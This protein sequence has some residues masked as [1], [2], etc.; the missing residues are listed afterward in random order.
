MKRVEIYN[1]SRNRLSLR[2]YDHNATKAEMVLKERDVYS[3][4]ARLSKFPIKDIRFNKEITDVMVKFDSF[5][6]KLINCDKLDNHERYL[7][8]L[9]NNM[10]VALEKKKMSEIKKSREKKGIKTPPK[11][12]RSNK[13]SK[14]KIL[15]GALSLY[16]LIGGVVLSSKSQAIDTPSYDDAISYNYFE[17]D[18]DD[19]I[20][21]DF[22]IVN[23]D[24]NNLTEEKTDA[25]DTES[26][27]LEYEDRSNTDKALTAKMQYGDIIDKYANQYG[28]DNRLVLAI[29]TQERGIHSPVMDKGG[30]TGLMQIQN[31][32]WVGNE[33]K[34]YNFE[35]GKEESFIIEKDMLSDLNKNIQIGCMVLQNTMQYMNYNILAAV[36]CYNM[37]YGNMTKILDAYA[38]S[39]GMTRNEVLS[40]QN[41]CGWL[42]YR[43]MI[44]VGDQKYVEHV[45]SWMGEDANIS[46]SSTSNSK[47]NLSVTNKNE[48][49]KVY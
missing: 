10:E 29:A 36:Q 8:P 46:V 27:Y 45:L 20:P 42:E 40:D 19:T 28:L 22:N 18:N 25:F 31:S 13:H 15:A 44:K 48:T 24:Y 12:A 11:V 26:L 32:V 9:L 14:A 35:L 6:I 4:L 33:I 21:N 43:D 5:V 23:V 7:H 3:Y 49:L 47:V 2:Q 41:D 37:G 16:M 17:K 34:A 1:D 30:A 38:S 39:K